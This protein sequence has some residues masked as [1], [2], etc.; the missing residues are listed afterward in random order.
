MQ[1][2]DR[3]ETLSDIAENAA[4]SMADVAFLS[5]LEE[6]TVYRLWNNPT[7]LDKVS[8]RSLQAL[9]ATVPGL[10]DYVA[11]HALTKRRASLIDDL[12]LEGLAVNQ[13]GVRNCVEAGTPEQY[14]S[15]ALQA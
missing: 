12:A 15:A 4:F 5:G 14:L 8:G 11:D 10:G 1:L 2:D 7:W 9:L 3:H 6:S 13:A